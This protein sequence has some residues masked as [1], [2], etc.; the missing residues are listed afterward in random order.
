MRSHVVLDSFQQLIADC[1]PDTPTHWLKKRADS[2]ATTM[3]ASVHEDN[4]TLY[5]DEGELTDRGVAYM[6]RLDAL[7]G[8]RY[9]RLRLG[10]WV[11]VEGQIQT[12]GDY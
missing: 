9:Q 11:G 2:G 1:N 8:T 5:T 3:L 6:A 10:K 7:T 12:V 4:P